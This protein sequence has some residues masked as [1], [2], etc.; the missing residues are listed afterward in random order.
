MKSLILITMLLSSTA[1]GVTQITDRS[2]NDEVGNSNLPVV[3][4]F[5]SQDCAP[6]KKLTTLLDVAEKHLKGRVK[7]VK[8]DVDESPRVG[9]VARKLP[10][11]V[12][13]E[14][15]TDKAYATVGV[16]PNVDALMK[17]ILET[18]QLEKK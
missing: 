14:P 18:F 3:M 16:P 12:Y 15:H 6:C 11:L 4:E 2:F 7:F 9:K 1:F 8:L 10:T 13:I 17:V 5:Y